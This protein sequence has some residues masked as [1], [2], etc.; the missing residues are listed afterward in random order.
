MPM[1][2]VATT[3][4]QRKFTD[5]PKFG[6]VKDNNDPLKLGRVKVEIEGIYEGSIETLPWV[7]RKMDTAF[8]G[9][10]CEIFDVPEVDSIVEV[11]WNYDDNVPMYS[12]VPYNKKHITGDFAENY[13]YEGGIKFGECLIKFDKASN[14]L[15][16]DNGK[17][18]I[19]LDSFGDVNI[20]C[21]R[22]SI[23][24]DGSAT[25]AAPDITLDGNVRVSGGFS[26]GNG[27]SG[28][29]TPSGLA[30]VSGGIIESIEN[31]G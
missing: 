7:R 9:N 14:I 1:I 11:R 3:A 28:V 15:T 20:A 27:A 19:V 2:P 21:N 24:C 29:I 16:L 13:P 6:T 10:N 4:K 12:G 30:A 8:C 25:I 5:L 23:S 17:A 22:I 31:M 18:Q 26:A